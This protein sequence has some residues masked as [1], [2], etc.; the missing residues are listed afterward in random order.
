MNKAIKYYGSIAVSLLLC[1]SLTH[2]QEYASTWGPPVDAPMPMLEAPDH[3]GE[4]RTLADL[5]GEQGLLL[6]L[7]RSADW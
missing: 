6:F 7:S 3:T 1:A 2:A 5:A 4:L